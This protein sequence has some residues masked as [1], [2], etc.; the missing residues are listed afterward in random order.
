MTGEF[1]PRDFVLG[2]L[3][4]AVLLMVHYK[5]SVTGRD[6]DSMIAEKMQDTDCGP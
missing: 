6:I 1:S 5:D 4:A 2:L 3:F